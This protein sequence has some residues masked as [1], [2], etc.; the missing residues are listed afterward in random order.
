MK[1]KCFRLFATFCIIG[2]CMASCNNSN[3]SG[4]VEDSDSVEE[5]A[6]Q[7]SFATVDDVQR[8]IEG[9]IWTYTE[10]GSKLWFKLVFRNGMADFY[11]SF[12]AKGEWGEPSAS[13]CYTIEEHRYSNTG[14]RYV[15]VDM[16]RDYSDEHWC[17]QLIPENGQASFG[18]GNPFIMNPTDYVWD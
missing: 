16:K 13:Y 8:N 3:V 15:A 7:K 10:V 11:C 17:Y 6:V 4:P 1:E 18:F 2:F 9:T 14:E 12:P 5:I